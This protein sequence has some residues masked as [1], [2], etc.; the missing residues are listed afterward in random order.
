MLIISEDSGADVLSEEGTAR[1]LLFPE[2]SAGVE[3]VTFS[4]RVGLLV[5]ASFSGA[6]AAVMSKLGRLLYLPTKNGR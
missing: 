2:I 1:L 3:E 4:D 5:Q 6:E